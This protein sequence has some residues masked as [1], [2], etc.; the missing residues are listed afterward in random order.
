MKVVWSIESRFTPGLS[1]GFVRVRVEPDEVMQPSCWLPTDQVG[2]GMLWSRVAALARVQVIICPKK[3]VSWLPEDNEWPAYSSKVFF[4]P[5]DTGIFQKDN[6]WIH[7]AQIVNECPT[8]NLSENLWD[9][10][11]KLGPI[12]QLSHHLGQDLGDSAEAH[13]SNTTANTQR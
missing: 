8:L 3:E 5:N 6:V 1:A 13:G 11:E 4:F 12:L 9:V 10:L 7:Q 2:G